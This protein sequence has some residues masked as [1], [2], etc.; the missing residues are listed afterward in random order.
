MRNL[1]KV[2]RYVSRIEN[3]TLEDDTSGC[4]GCSAS[5]GFAGHG[6]SAGGVFFYNF[7]FILK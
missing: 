7:C 6:H 1:Q 3:S 5:P 2:R 4:A